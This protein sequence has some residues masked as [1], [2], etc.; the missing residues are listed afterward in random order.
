MTIA[1]E[2]D[3]PA[4]DYLEVIRNKT[5]ILFAAAAASGAEAPGLNSHNTSGT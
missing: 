4:E 5:A 2:P 1:G 3:T